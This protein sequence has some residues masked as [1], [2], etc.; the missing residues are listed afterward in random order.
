MLFRSLKEAIGRISAAPIIPYPPGIPLIAPGE[1]I[2]KDIYDHIL[3]LLD[4]GLE[5]VGLMGYNKDNVV[6]VER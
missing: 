1:E 6:V 4:N 3:F 5:I 2:T